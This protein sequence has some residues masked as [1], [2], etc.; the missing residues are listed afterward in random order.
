MQ[1]ADPFPQSAPIEAPAKPKRKP[2]RRR[3]LPAAA[4]PPKPEKPEFLGLT[5][6]ACCADCCME[7]CVITGKALCGHPRKGGLQPP[8]MLVPETMA[9]YQRAV[10]ALAHAA[11][12]TPAG[13]RGT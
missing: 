11:I 2:A 3:A 7:K 8:D 1:D 5:A 9:R 13:A 4:A 6:D 12:E 10:K